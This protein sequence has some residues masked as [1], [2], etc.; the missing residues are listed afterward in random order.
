MTPKIATLMTAARMIATVSI[1]PSR[2]FEG[3]QLSH[4]AA[5]VRLASDGRAN[6][7]CVV[8]MY[9]TYE[10]SPTD[11]GRGLARVHQ[12]IFYEQSNFVDATWHLRLLSG[13]HP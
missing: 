3:T 1:R 10:K 12:R 13:P 9:P 4:G 6:P 8:G 11:W 5:H 2:C 7:G